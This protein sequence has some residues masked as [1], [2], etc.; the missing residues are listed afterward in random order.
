MPEWLEINGVKYGI[1]AS[2]YTYPTYDSITPTL[3]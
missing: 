3:R 1:N 2:L